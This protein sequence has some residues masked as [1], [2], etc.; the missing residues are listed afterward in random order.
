MLSS[1]TAVT[2]QSSI[3]KTGG[4][5]YNHRLLSQAAKLGIEVQHLTWADFAL[6]QM[7]AKPV[8]WRLRPFLRALWLSM[9]MWRGRG[10]VFAD[11]WMAPYL[12]LWVICSRRP[13]MVMAHHL[14]GQLEQSFWVAL[15]EKILLR[16][17]MRILTVSQSSEQQIKALLRHEV[18]ID[19]IPPGFERL[20]IAMKANQPA[21]AVSL[22][23]VGHIT[24]AKGVL[25]LLHAAA[26]LPMDIP[27]HMH[28]AGASG[29]EPDTAKALERLRQSQHLAEHITLH[30]R[31]SDR[32]LQQLY[33][34]AD[35]LV[36]PSYWE[37]YGIVFLEAMQYGLPIVSTT[38]G[39][40]PE[41]VADGHTGLLVEAGDV[42]ALSHA[43]GQLI[44]S[45]SLRQSYGQQG[46]ER[47]QQMTDWTQT[48]ALFKHW[49]Q[50][51]KAE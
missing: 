2:G 16:R 40:I 23:F 3:G 14:R 51:R 49:W 28:I 13:V 10:V 39:A 41:V 37:G 5:G 45:A 6:D 27:W 29:A 26:K 50:Q 48:E 35:V 4:E 30:G 32:A 9:A 7:L 43:L 42:Q 17:A 24:R 36:L 38:A 8:I 33:A 47:V 25:D 44:G 18:A 34:T 21:E 11:I 1:I 12:I 31:V 15:A 46:L 19:R 22:L 20:N